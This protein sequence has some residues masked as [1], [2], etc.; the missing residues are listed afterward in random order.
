MKRQ[1]LVEIDVLVAI[2]LG[3][4]LQELKTIYR[5]QFPVLKQNK[6]KHFYDL[7]GE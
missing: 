7:N 1:A 4:S 2:E 3:L 5:I 6:M